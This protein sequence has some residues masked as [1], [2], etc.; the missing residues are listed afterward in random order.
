MA[1]RLDETNLYEKLGEKKF[2]EL[3]TAFYEK[4]YN[5]T[6]ES[7]RILFAGSKK[8]EAIQNQYEFFIQRFGGP[9]LYSERKGHPAL[10]FRH[11]NFQITK[12][13]ADRWLALMKQALE[14]VGI[15][16]DT[17][18]IMLQFF[19]HTA[20]LLQNIAEDGSRIYG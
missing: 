6:D 4:V 13:H 15:C 7:F 3:S 8:E 14:L 11:V 19:E 1:F 20:Y 5:D 18:D 9:N 2:V 17:R 16:G 12:Q 10:R